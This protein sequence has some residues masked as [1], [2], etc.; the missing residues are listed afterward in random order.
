MTSFMKCPWDLF[1]YLISTVISF[2]N[3]AFVCF[4]V[5]P[6]KNIKFGLYFYKTLKNIS[7][8]L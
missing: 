6:D 7:L 1:E 4:L 2:N 5:T 3:Y 8:L